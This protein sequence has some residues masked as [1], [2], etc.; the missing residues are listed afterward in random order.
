MNLKLNIYDN[1]SD[2]EDY[3][4]TY[5]SP[6]QCAYELVNAFTAILVKCDY[7]D[8][9]WSSTFAHILMSALIYAGRYDD[10]GY[11]QKTLYDILLYEQNDGEIYCLQSHNVRK[12]IRKVIQLLMRKCIQDLSNKDKSLHK[13]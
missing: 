8:T 9:M 11:I 1:L 2:Y 4:F 13:K 7:N 10:G 12:K 5:S 3:R 6:T